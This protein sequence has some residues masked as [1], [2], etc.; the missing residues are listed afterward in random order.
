MTMVDPVTSWFEQHQL[1]DEP[2]AYTCQQILDSV[3]I[4]R[5]P[6]L[7]KIGFNDGSEFN[8]EFKD[9]CNNMG[10]KQCLNNAWNPQSNAIL[11]RI[12][13]VLADGLV[14]FELENK[15]IGVNK[16]GRLMNI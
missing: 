11:E 2:N 15:P 10:V 16:D 9:L 3:L 13:Q 4:S 12:H 8:M 5:Y 14:T 7:K 1:Y 6:R